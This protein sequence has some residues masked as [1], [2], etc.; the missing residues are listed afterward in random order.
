M[1]KFLINTSN[2]RS[3]G[4]EEM[5]Q[6]WDLDPGEGAHLSGHPQDEAGLCPGALGGRQEEQARI[7]TVSA[8]Q[9]ERAAPGGLGSHCP[10]DVLQCVSPHSPRS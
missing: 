10:A 5:I 3:Y 9:D 2:L 8:H 7:P 1:G 6:A 4:D